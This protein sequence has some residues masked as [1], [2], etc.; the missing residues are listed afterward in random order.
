MLPAKLHRQGG[1]C[2]L[3]PQRFFRWEEGGISSAMRYFATARRLTSMPSAD[4]AIRTDSS[5]SGASGFSVLIR[6]WMRCLTAWEET[7]ASE[8]IAVVKKLR[9]GTI[10]PRYWIY[11]FC[12]VRLTV[13]VLMSI[14][15]AICCIVIGVRV[16]PEQKKS[17]CSNPED[18]VIPRE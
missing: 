14:F 2:P 1:I 7:E 12:I 3:L 15:S 5:E 13:D 9:R 17:C 11:L 16:P 18:W 8:R 10:L 6:S 4:S